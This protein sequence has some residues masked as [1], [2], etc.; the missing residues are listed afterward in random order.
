MVIIG[1]S[2]ST[3]RGLLLQPRPQDLP[4]INLLIGSAIVIASGLFLL[5][6]ETRRVPV[7]EPD[8]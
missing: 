4:I 1:G 8:T 7:E 6:R 5:W 2:R 3:R